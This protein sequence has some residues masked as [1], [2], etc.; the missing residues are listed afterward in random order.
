[1]EILLLNVKRLLHVQGR[2]S[3]FTILNI[4]KYDSSNLIR[5]AKSF[6]RIPVYIIVFYTSNDVGSCEIRALCQAVVLILY[7]YLAA[8][9]EL[10]TIRMVH[11]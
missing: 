3:I 2:L 6:F 4:S 1:M 10:I 11:S 7:G 9:T 5:K 8:I